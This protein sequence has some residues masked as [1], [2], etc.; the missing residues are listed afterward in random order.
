MREISSGGVVYR[1]RRGVTEVALIRVGRRWCLPKGQVE[2]G[3]KL[4]ETA[5]REVS[6]ETGLEGSGVSS[7]ITPQVAAMIGVG[8]LEGA[9]E[10]ARDVRDGFALPSKHFEE[11]FGYPFIFPSRLIYGEL[12]TIP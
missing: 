6:E 8:A 4:E 2:E 9:P 7:L 5:L 10:L 11:L 3:E 12:P 1:E